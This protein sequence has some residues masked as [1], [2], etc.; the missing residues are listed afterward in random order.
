M[1]MSTAFKLLD[2]K[3]LLENLPKELPIVVTNCSQ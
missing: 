3:V 2:L 1:E